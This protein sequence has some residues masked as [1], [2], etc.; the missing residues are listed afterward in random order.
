VAIKIIEI[1]ARHQD[2]DRVREYLESNGAEFKGLDHQVDTYFQVQSGRLKL[3]EGT[4]E[5]SFIFYDRPIQGAPKR[6]DVVLSRPSDPEELKAVL[7]A[8]LPVRVVV[9]KQREIYFI[10]NVKFHIDDVNELG[11]FVEIEAIDASGERTEAELLQQCEFYMTELGV[12]SEN[13][14][15]ESYSELLLG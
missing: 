10:D 5:N 6:S 7:I 3:R 4:I 15:P 2:L 12:R 8:S 13:L 11:Q 1:K 14:V 9:D